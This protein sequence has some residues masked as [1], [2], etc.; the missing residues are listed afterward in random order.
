MK[1]RNVTAQEILNIYGVILQVSIEPRNLGG[2]SSYLE[3]ISRIRCGQGYTYSLDAYGGWAS[4]IMSLYS[5]RKIRSEYHNEFGEYEV[6]DKCHKMTFLIHCINQATARNFDSVQMQLLTKGEQQ[7]AFTSDVSVNTIQIKQ[8]KRRIDFFV[9]SNRKYYFVWNID[10]YQGNNE[11]NI[12]IHHRAKQ[13]PTMMKEVINSVLASSIANGHYSAWKISLD[14]MY[15]CQYIFAI[16]F[17]QIKIILGG[18]Y[19]KNRIGFQG[20]DEQQTLPKYAK[21]LAHRRLYNR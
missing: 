21:I 6:G 1:R 7:L 18:T 14:N 10:M 12:D 17:K 11:G 16:L 15:A 20:N 4:K 9:F 2:Y 8:E 5:F 3:S 13:L 19:R